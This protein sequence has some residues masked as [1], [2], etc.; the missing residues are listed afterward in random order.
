[1]TQRRMQ[2]SVITAAAA[3]AMTSVSLQ[4]LW[5]SARISVQARSNRNPVVVYIIFRSHDTCWE[6]ENT[7]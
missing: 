2:R 4:K 7:I 3:A 1:M 5:I 6:R